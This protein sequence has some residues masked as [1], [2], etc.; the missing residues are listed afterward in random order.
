MKKYKIAVVDDDPMILMMIK[1]AL[2]EQGHLEI[3]TF[4]SGEELLKL[5]NV[6]NPDVLITDYY[7]DSVNKDAMRGSDLIIKL[8]QKGVRLPIIILSSQDNMKLALELSKFEVADYIEKS[9]DYTKRI[10]ES[11]NDIIAMKGVNEEIST[12]DNIMKKDYNRI[13]KISVFM[14]VVLLVIGIAY[15]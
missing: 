11:I 12:V 13:I 10:N 6:V 15:R 1:L 3:V 7:M 2:E 4:E 9:D 8:Y 5:Y 14:V